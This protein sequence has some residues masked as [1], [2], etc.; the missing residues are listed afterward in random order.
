MLATK[1]KEIIG[2]P[3]KWTKDDIKELGN[4]VGELLPSELKQIGDQ[5]IKDSLQFLKDVDF[6]IDQVKRGGWSDITHY[7][8]Q[9]DICNENVQR[10]TAWLWSLHHTYGNKIKI[11]KLFY[12]KNC[13]TSLRAKRVEAV[14]LENLQ[15]SYV[16]FFLTN[17]C[18]AELV[19][20]RKRN[21]RENLWMCIFLIRF[22]GDFFFMKILATSYFILL[23]PFVDM[24]YIKWLAGRVVYHIKG[25]YIK[26]LRV[27]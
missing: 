11:K 6:K 16:R 13:L 17:A 1:A 19:Y 4:I 9:E 3:D 20:F 5:V 12:C 24:S 21:V 23:H 10:E 27:N 8:I 26:F 25:N 18:Y 2:S 14:F 22:E 7:R 15:D